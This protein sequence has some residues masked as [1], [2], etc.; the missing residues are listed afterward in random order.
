MELKLVRDGEFRP[1]VLGGVKGGSV[2]E[3]ILALGGRDAEISWEDVFKGLFFPPPLTSFLTL[4]VCR[5]RDLLR[6]RMGWLVQMLT[7]YRRRV[8]GATYFPRRDG[9]ETANGFLGVSL[10]IGH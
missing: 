4:L 3:D 10:I 8:Q 2:H 7:P 6:F 1:A 5:G 9:E